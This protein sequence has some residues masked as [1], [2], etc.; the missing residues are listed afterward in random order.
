MTIGNLKPTDP[1]TSAESVFG[2][3][4]GWK[5]LNEK[6]LLEPIK[7][8]SRW[9]AAFGSLLLF[10]FTL[11]VV[12]GILLTTYYAPS[13]TTAWQSV[14]YIQDEVP[15]GWLVRGMH[16]W[17]SSAMVILLLLHLVQVFIWG[18]YKRPREI[19]WMSGVLLLLATLGLAFTGY[20]LPWDERAYWSSK[21]G[22]GIASTTPII[23]EYL[24]T[25]LQ[26]G[27]DMGNLTLTRFFTLHGF[28]LPGSIIAIIMAHLYLFRR[29]GVTTAWWK[30][31]PQLLKER[32]PF[33]PGQVW[34]DAVFAFILLAALVAWTWTHPAPLSNIA[35]PSKPY[36]ARP[37][38]YFM[39]LFQLLKYFKG[40]YEILGTFVLPSLF[41]GILLFWP[42]LDRNPSHDPR[43]RPLALSLLILGVIGLVGLTVFA[44]STDTRMAEPAAAVASAPPVKPS[45][46]IFQ[47]LDTIN[48]YT[49]SCLPCHA[50][51][52]TG[53]ML[54]VAL[55]TIP[56]FTSAKWQKA[57][58]E[59]DMFRRIY[60]GKIDA[61]KPLMP[62]FKDKLSIDQIRSLVDY[63]RAFSTDAAKPQ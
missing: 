17:G 42:F 51:D 29:H 6:L 43:K 61:G 33:W 36:A 44:V 40:S 10:A 4:V 34:K 9:A 18:A 30:G 3:R 54:R 58:K 48:V 5:E 60:D 8:G 11:Q 57:Q 38:W 56:D 14:K 22:L 2:S 28:I 37:E 20:L 59:D 1:L 19:T 50:V 13:T 24:R 46:P 45:A 31:E 26:G 15:L 23:G 63:T 53:N 52:G 25:L 47:K 35:D 41:V 16:H 21:V 49:A 32:E 62:P 27:S 39:F 55:P 12:T 7:G